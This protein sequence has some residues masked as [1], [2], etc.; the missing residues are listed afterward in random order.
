[1]TGSFRH[2]QRGILLQ[3]CNSEFTLRT[4]YSS[5]HGRCLM[6]TIKA[7]LQSYKIISNSIGHWQV[8]IFLHRVIL[9]VCGTD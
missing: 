5:G 7:S 6:M 9:P 1:M 2:F 8:S 3:Q 4:A